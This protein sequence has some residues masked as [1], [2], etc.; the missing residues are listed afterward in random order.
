[1][2]E[3]GGP[4][5]VVPRNVQGAFVVFVFLLVRIAFF[6]HLKYFFR[7]VN[8]CRHIL[9]LLHSRTAAAVLSLVTLDSLN[10]T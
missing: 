2:Q 8:A 10:S 6:V 4:D 1:M 9:T 7:T 5:L 3:D